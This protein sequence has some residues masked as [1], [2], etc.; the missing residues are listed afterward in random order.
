LII[1]IALKPGRDKTA[2]QH[3]P[4][5]FSGAIAKIDGNPRAGDVVKVID[6]HNNFVAYG[7]YSPVSQIRI[8]LLEWDESAAIDNAWWHKKIKASIERRNTITQ[9]ANTNAVRL[10]Y[11]ESDFIPG[12]IVD[13]YD[14]F[15]IAQFLS[16]GVDAAKNTI[17]ATLDEIAKPRGIYERGDVDVRKLEGLELR[18]GNL[19]GAKP[20]NEIIIDERKIKFAVDIVNG[21][22]TGMYLDQRYNRQAVAEFAAGKRILDCF[23]YSGGFSLYAM[24]SK[25]KNITL[26]DSSQSALDTANRNIELNGFDVSKATFVTGDVFE[27]LRELKSLGKK[28]DMI[29]LDPP[30]FAPTKNDL[31]KALSAYKD[32][33]LL[34]LQLL[35]PGGILATFSCSGAVDSQTL[36]TVLFWAAID[37]GREVQIIQKLSQDIDHPISVT[38]PES[39]Y[40]KGCMCRVI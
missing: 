22:K 21:H 13:R 12:L 35:E 15:L 39:E 24:A 32:I 20:P 23:C 19:S 7:H 31:K 33:N 2:R 11:G 3:H 36:Q 34:A 37:S 27:V 10:I 1:K 14:D 4:W 9:L 5:I 26:V 17:V 6:G 28:F 8:R 38:F 16:C 18:K 40:L 30:K 25:C 29:I